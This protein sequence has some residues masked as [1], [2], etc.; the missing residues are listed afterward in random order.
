MSIGKPSVNAFLFT[1]DDKE[2]GTKYDAYIDIVAFQDFANFDV[3][4]KA[5]GADKWTF[6]NSSLS[7]GSS[8]STALDYNKM[9]TKQ[10]V[11]DWLQR[12]IERYNLIFAEK[13][14]KQS[15]EPDGGIEFAQ[16]L[17]RTGK[18]SETDNV[19]TLD[20]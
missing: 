15:V 2:N 12:C 10:E 14:G 16:W 7:D 3:R 9:V 13:F 20:A 19:L 5:Q 17:L 8:F 11:I 6:L 18:L 4:Y 1:L